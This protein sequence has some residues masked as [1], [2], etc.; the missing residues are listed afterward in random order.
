MRTQALELNSLGSNPCPAIAVGV[1]L[2][3]EDPYV[4]TNGCKCLTR[5][6]ILGEVSVDHVGKYW[7]FVANCMLHLQ[8]T[9]NNRANLYQALILF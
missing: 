8:G 2:G 4:Y 7:V 1:S 6:F 9:D 3:N 5:Y